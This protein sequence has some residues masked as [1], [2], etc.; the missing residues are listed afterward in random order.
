MGVVMT[1]PTMIVELVH[2]NATLPQRA[3]Q[4]DAGMDVF[5]PIDFSIPMGMSAK[6]SLGWKCEI[7]D[8]WVL[9]V[10]NKSGHAVNRGLD[11]G[12]E[13]IDS[14]YR[15]EVHIHLFNHSDRPA[16]FEAG[17]KIAQLLLMPVWVGQPKVGKIDLDTDRGDG[18]FGST[19]IK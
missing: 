4:S 15:G 1:Q 8:G 9:L 17:D 18:G 11:K 14:G 16:F 6:V 13:V 3:H 12:A 5:T 10:F 19:G 2:K 7:P